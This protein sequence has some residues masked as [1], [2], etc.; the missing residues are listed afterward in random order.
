MHVPTSAEKKKKCNKI[1]EGRIVVGGSVMSV[2]HDGSATLE[3]TT[4]GNHSLLRLP[5]PLRVQKKV[6]MI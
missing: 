1:C 4:A 3:T 5:R 2:P 6:V